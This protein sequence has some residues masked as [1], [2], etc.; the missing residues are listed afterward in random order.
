MCPSQ[1]FPACPAPLPPHSCPALYGLV[2]LLCHCLWVC[3]PG[4]TGGSHGGVS[5]FSWGYLGE[6][7]EHTGWLHTSLT[8]RAQPLAPEATTWRPG[9]SRHGE[10]A[11]RAAL[12]IPETLKGETAPPG[13][14]PVLILEKA[15]L[16]SL[17]TCLSSLKLGA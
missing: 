9:L 12:Q 8:S 14:L 6:E 16:L 10:K 15:A 7:S 11:W 17:H 3:H 1:Q 5:G 2:V 13:S 4:H